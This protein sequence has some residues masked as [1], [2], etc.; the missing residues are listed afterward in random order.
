MMTCAPQVARMRAASYPTP[1]VPP[2]MTITWPDSATSGTSGS[3]GLNT[4]LATNT[5]TAATAAT[6]TATV[7]TEHR[8][9][10][11]C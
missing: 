7:T 1:F 11:A 5:D 4:R 8:M 6:A 2:V 10:V 3:G 9:V